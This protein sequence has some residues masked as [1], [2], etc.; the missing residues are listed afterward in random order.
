ML[1]FALH[2]GWEPRVVEIATGGD[3][4]GSLPEENG[5]DFVDM[6]YF[7]LLGKL[8]TFLQHDTSKLPTEYKDKFLDEGIQPIVPG[9][10]NDA[11]SFPSN[12]VRLEHPL[13]R[14]TSL[15]FHPEA[16]FVWVSDEV[17]TS[18][19]VNLRR[20]YG[21]QLQSIQ[22]IVIEEDVWDDVSQIFDILETLQSVRYMVI[23]L[24]SYRFTAGERTATEEEYSQRA[25]ELQQRHQPAL[26]GRSNLLVEYVDLNGHVYG[27]FRTSY[28][29]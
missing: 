17:D 18:A 13:L 15:H 19:L 8:Q 21:A 7:R 20:H 24:E 27:R 5:S 10:K 28:D 29:I 16:D 26:D 14:D 1:S 11:R 25:V 3:V 22:N 23:W 9:N 4:K 2:R 6:N 12:L